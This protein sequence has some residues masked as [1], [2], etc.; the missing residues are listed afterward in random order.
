MQALSDEDNALYLY[1]RL[2][3]MCNLPISIVENNIFCSVSRFQC[4]FKRTTIVEVMFALVERV[5]KKIAAEMSGTIGVLMYDGGSS[6]S[7]HYV[8][9]Y[10]LYNTSVPCMSNGRSSSQILTRCNLLSVSPMVQIS[11]EE[12]S[13]SSTADT[14]SFNA[15][16]QLQFFKDSLQF[17]NLQFSEW[18]LCLVGDNASTNLRVAR[19]GNVPHVGCSSHKLHLEV[20]TMVASHYDM[21]N[22]IDSVRETMTSARARLKNA[23]ILRNITDLRPRIDNTT[24]WSGK[25]YILNQF[26][27]M[28]SDLIEASD[29][30][31]CDRVVNPSIAFKNKT[32][33]YT[34]MLKEINEVTKSLQRKGNTLADYRDD[35]NALIEAVQDEKGNI[36]SPF[37]G[38]RLGTKY[39]A[40]DSNIVKYKEF[41]SGIVKLQ[42]GTQEDLNDDEKEALL[43]FKKP[44]ALAAT[45][46]SE[47]SKLSISERMAKKRKV[48]QV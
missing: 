11:D 1:I 27:N 43:R 41:E 4:L 37:Y 45:P 30:P 12:E 10:G 35:L 9:L 24:R 5:E 21:K 20:N 18:C 22:T 7:T 42:K 38:C 15:D 48:T 6:S 8:A 36:G 14:S 39:I 46:S 16:V 3:F 17:Y 23:A 31:G 33:R 29:E 34:R 47:V 32:T 44:N 25:Y 26:V 13:S 40:C 28:R 19:I 2:N